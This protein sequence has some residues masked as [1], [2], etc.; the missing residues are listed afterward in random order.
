M[1]HLHERMQEL[2]VNLSCCI[3]VGTPSCHNNYTRMYYIEYTVC[4]LHNNYSNLMH[5]LTVNKMVIHNYTKCISNT[6]YN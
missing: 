5:N 3:Y 2:V 6:D 1:I 4:I